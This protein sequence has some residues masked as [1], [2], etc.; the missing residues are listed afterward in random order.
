MKISFLV[1]TEFLKHQ[2]IYTML[3]MIEAAKAKSHEI[4][5]VFFFG[6]SVVSLKKNVKLGKDT[7]NVPE[8]IGS[9]CKENIPVYACQTWADNY[10]VFSEDSEDV[11]EGIQV[12]GLGELSNMT[13]ESDKLVVFGARA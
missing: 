6:T 11:C 1:M 5:G 12:L 7:R 3:K 10:G 13:Y 2:Q 9:L 4:K 8:A